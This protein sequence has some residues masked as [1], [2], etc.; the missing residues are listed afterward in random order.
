MSIA[1]V[2]SAAVIDKKVLA[3]LVDEKYLQLC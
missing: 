2:E 3:R 1:M